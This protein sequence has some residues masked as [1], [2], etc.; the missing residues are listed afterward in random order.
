MA[1]VIEAAV[2]HTVR[3]VGAAVTT[4]MLC[5][6]E[7][8]RLVGSHGLRPEVVERW[9]R[10]SIAADT[11]ASEAVRLR[12]P[13]LRQGKVG[14]H[15]PPLR[16]EA[17]P[18][19]SVVCL[20]LGVETPVGVIGMSFESG[21]LPG[22][23][24]LDLLMLFA[25]SC[26]QAIRRVA[27]ANEAAERSQQLRFLA[28]ASLELADSLD[29]R[30]T[31]GNVARLVVPILADWC[32]V[33]ILEAEEIQTVAVAHA[34]PEWVSWAWEYRSRH[35]LARD[36]S[37]GVA[38]A[39][40][41]GASELI[42]EI[43]DEMLRAAAHDE[44]QL[45]LSRQLGLRSAII[46]PLT[47]PGR[48][49]GALTLVRSTDERHYTPA[50]LALAE[51]LGRRA[52]AAIENAELHSQ[53]RDSALRLQRALL[54]DR[55]DHLPGWEVAC[56]Y[57]P[58]GHAGIGGDFYD[59]VPLPDGRLAVFIGDVMGHGL[60]AAAAMAHVR[61]AVRAYLTVDPEP[62][63][64]I[65]KI[66]RMVEQLRT[67][68]LASLLYALIDPTRRVIDIASAGHHPALLVR[69]DGRTSWVSTAF[70]PMLGVQGQLS[71][72]RSHEFAPGDTMLMF[73]DG[74]VER[75]DE[76]VDDRLQ[77]TL[78][79]A[80]QLSRAPLQP[81]VNALISQLGDAGEDDIAVIAV[82]PRDGGQKRD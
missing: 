8:L 48:V 3:P 36:Q 32:T 70:R 23:R 14:E 61:A 57:A 26:G 40:R 59:A 37:H 15:Y 22:R 30:T 18:Q 47:T 16:Q 44:E 55:L 69:G 74:L 79:L 7:Q 31:L 49:L 39:L 29:Y 9:Q 77:R 28:D 17:P 51:D 50:D 62:A 56:Y 45:R 52:G 41:S 33:E 46:V 63:I 12:R 60:P 10:F 2:E 80:A 1:E 21:W 58:G 66:A 4:L 75:R 24:D 64:V 34:D 6:A 27:A 68:T 81:A 19:R 71:A 53:L 67:T 82:R 54:P 42:P 25:E 13:I 11:P 38:K 76:P 73:T 43:S 20:P 5:E 72:M 78:Q 65:G 35:P